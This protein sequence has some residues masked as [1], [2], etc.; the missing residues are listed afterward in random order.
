[1]APRAWLLLWI[2]LSGRLHSQAALALVERNP[3]LFW[4]RGWA[5]PLL[6]PRSREPF[7]R[8]PELNPHPPVVHPLP[9]QHHDF[10]VR[11]YGTAV[12]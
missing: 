11:A 10:S 6:T 9:S 8:C 1:M 5:G 3:V 7:S 4:T 2:R 12:T